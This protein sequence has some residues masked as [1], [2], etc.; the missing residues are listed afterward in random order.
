MLPNLEFHTHIQLSHN[1]LFSQIHKFVIK[2]TLRLYY[3]LE[4]KSLR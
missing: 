4:D 2:K 1:R 3:S